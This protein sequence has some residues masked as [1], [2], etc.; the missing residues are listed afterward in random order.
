MNV[1]NYAVTIA[2]VLFNITNV[3]SQNKITGDGKLTYEKVIQFD[4][5]ISVDVIYSKTKELFLTQSSVIN[6]YHSKANS[7][8]KRDAS[9][10]EDLRRLM[11]PIKFTDDVNHIV[12]GSGSLQYYGTSMGCIRIVNLQFNVR[13]AIKTGRMKIEISDLTYTHNNQV[14]NAP[15]SFMTMKDAGPCKSQ[16]TIEDLIKCDKCKNELGQYFTF[17]NS[18]M[19]ELIN[20]FEKQLSGSLKK[21]D[22]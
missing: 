3:F 7:N 4:S 10:Y 20:E 1:K 21:Q 8:Q 18:D 22:W 16:G 11:E 12:V 19:P 14:S 5:S 13:V 6:R 2:V 9:K 17:L 15:M